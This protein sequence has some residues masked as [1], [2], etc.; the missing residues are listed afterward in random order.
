[1]KKILLFL[2]ITISI[3]SCRNSDNDI[4]MKIINL[5]VKSTDWVENVDTAGLNRYYS[6]HFSMPEITSS[7]FNNGTASAYIMLSNVQQVLPYVRHYEN[8]AG[9][10]WT[11]TIDFDYSVG[12]MNIYVTNSDFAV[13]PPGAMD[14]RI[15]LMW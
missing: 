3:I 10:L 13:D 7:I 1:M 15:V 12:G 9:E 5:T 4:N 11:Q 8:T 2:L 14:F 6:C